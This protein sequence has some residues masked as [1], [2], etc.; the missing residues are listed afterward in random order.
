MTKKEKSMEEQLNEDKAMEAAE[1][2]A[3]EAAEAEE[4][5]AKKAQK[6]WYIV[7]TIQGMKIR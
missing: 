2:E 5:K 1:Q 4:K 6:R 7:H 3:A